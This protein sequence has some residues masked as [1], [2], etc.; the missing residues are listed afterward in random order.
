VSAA[1]DGAENDDPSFDRYATAEDTTTVAAL[2]AWY[3]WDLTRAVGKWAGGEWNNEGVFLKSIAETS[4]TTRWFRSSEYAAD[5]AQRPQLV[6]TYS[7]AGSI[8]IA[9][10]GPPGAHAGGLLVAFPN[11]FAGSVTLRY[12]LA[13]PGPVRLR[14]Y[15]V[16]GRLRAVLDGTGRT[17][18]RHETIWDGRSADGGRLAAGTYFLRLDGTGIRETR[19]VVL[20]P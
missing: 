4:N 7:N 13:A 17:P 2:N 5:P 20:A 1:S 19:A 11:P 16:Q 8:A 15:D 14:V 10:G 6:V 9:G 18:G 3:E 12:E